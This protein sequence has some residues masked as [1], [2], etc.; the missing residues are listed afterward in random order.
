MGGGLVPL[1]E[2]LRVT[3]RFK[4]LSF[5]E[6]IDGAGDLAYTLILKPEK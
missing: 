3:Q 4:I 6:R 2:R 5:T 1:S